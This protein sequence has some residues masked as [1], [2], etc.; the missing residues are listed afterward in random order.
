MTQGQ[1]KG[2]TEEKLC[3]WQYSIE[4]AKLWMPRAD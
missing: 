1:F 2:H 3:F 4:V